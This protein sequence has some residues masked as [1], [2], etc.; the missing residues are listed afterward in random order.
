MKKIFI[1]TMLSALILLSTQSIYAQLNE[2]FSSTALASVAWNNGT[3][4][5]GPLPAGWTQLNLDNATPTSGYLAAMGTNAWVTA[6]FGLGNG[7]YDTFAMSISWYNPANTSNDYLI[8]PPFTIPAGTGNYLSW[9]AVCGNTGYPDGYKVYIG[10]SANPSSFTQVFSTPSAGGYI[11]SQAVDIS[12]YAGQTVYV[13]FRNDSYDGTFLLVDDIKIEQ[14]TT[15]DV[16]LTSAYLPKF[17]A[18]NQDYTIEG[19]VTNNGLPVNS[20]EVTWN[21]GSS[22]QVAT[23]NLPAALAPYASADFSHTVKFNKATSGFYNVNLNVTKVNGAVDANTA[24]N[25]TDLTVGVTSK[26][27]TKYPVFEE[28]TGTWCGWCPRGAVAMD[29]LTNKYSDFVGIAVHNGDPMVVTEYDNGA[30]FTGFPSANID[31][32]F[33]DVGVSLNN[34]ESYYT[35]LKEMSGPVDL[36][37]S[38]YSVAGSA[39]TVNAKADFAIAIP[40]EVRLAAIVVEDGVTG[41]SAGYSQANYYA[42]GQSGPMGGYENLANPVPYSSMVY[43]HV[44]RAL[45]GGYGGQS[46]SVGSSTT[47]GQQATYTFNYT[48]PA[49]VDLAKSHVVVLAIRSSNGEILN[50]FSVDGTDAIQGLD[51][52]TIGMN[53]YPNP[54]A[55]A[56]LVNVEF[57]INEKA[58]VTIYSAVGNVV[59]QK[60]IN[61]GDSKVTFDVSDVAAGQYLM[62]IATD[63]ASYTKV[64]TVSK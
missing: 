20:I 26:A 35:F 47:D 49:G 29:S 39:V 9:N 15:N 59:S 58:T 23:I 2:T 45:L 54:V 16:A 7:V 43:N 3:I 64:F 57:D 10:T 6:R 41:N 40:D 63:K 13:A 34:F 61:K 52:N 53:I 38:T 51:A 12:A 32:R 8:S 17:V 4:Q 33:K 21:D 46:G 28:G 48:A 36:S 31:R 19:S 27:N 44:G 5:A 42:G 22:P 11:A 18:A 60:T 30:G 62:T 56:N 1:R 14:F 37:G 50:A 55:S 24:D 25:T